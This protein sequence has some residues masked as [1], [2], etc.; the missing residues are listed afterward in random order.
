M[1]AATGGNDTNPFTS[2]DSVVSTGSSIAAPRT[3]AD[4]VLIAHGMVL[5]LAAFT[6]CHF[7]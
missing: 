6:F 2:N 5:S 1:V 4:R 3:K 7:M